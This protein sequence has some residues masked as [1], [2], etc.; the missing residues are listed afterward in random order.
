MKYCLQK[1]VV[2]DLQ[3]SP[4]S[5]AAILAALPPSSRR[6]R[7]I[8]DRR[9]PETRRLRDDRPSMV[10]KRMLE[11]SGPDDGLRP[12]AEETELSGAAFRVRHT[13]P[14]NR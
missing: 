8:I 1:Y 3:D 5:L 7:K 12:E 13:Q 9:K 10:T 11:E 14:D 6:A 4:T 2:T